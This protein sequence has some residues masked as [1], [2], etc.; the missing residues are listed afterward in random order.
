MAN[1]DYLLVVGPGRS[2]SRFLLRNLRGHPD[3]AF[4]RI[5]SE[6][7]YRSARR[8]RQASR[9]LQGNAG[10]L[11]VDI[12]N[13][14]YRDSALGPGVARLRREG[15]R[16]L[17]VVL[18]RDHRE[19]AVSMMRFR[20]SRGEL[21]ALSSVRRLETA[22]VR[23]RL[24]PEQ[25]EHLFRLDADVLTIAFPTLVNRTETVMGVLASR[26]G[27][28]EFAA[29]ERDVVNESVAARS[30]LFSS[31]GKSVAVALRWLRWM[32]LLRRLK[33]SKFVQG[34]FFASADSSEVRL[35]I[36]SAGVLDAA[37]AE[38][39]SVIE[40]NSERLAEGLYFHEAKSAPAST[41][42]NER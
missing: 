28:S 39:R 24:T 36:A 29:I 35:D 4:G 41:R 11:L 6:Y 42:G 3:L 27:I 25:L 38:C 37:H 26:C 21:S 2:G 9:R 1:Y 33:D 23:D 13:L 18:L 20:R 19:R 34:L 7:Y 8:F 16:I 15:A 17:L 22:V 32:G 10:K 14:G 5:E 31:F 12:A 30:L 40:A